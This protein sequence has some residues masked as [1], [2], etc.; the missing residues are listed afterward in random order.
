MQ[1]DI[2]PVKNKQPKLIT[3]LKNY[4]HYLYKEY[5][6]TLAYQ[7]LKAAHDLAWAR[8]AKT[9]TEWDYDLFW[10][11]CKGGNEFGFRIGYTSGGSTGKSFKL[12]KLGILVWLSNPTKNRSL[13]TSTT[14]LAS[15]GRI[16]GKV[17]NNL[18]R[19][20]ARHPYIEWEFGEAKNSI[21]IKPYINSKGEQVGGKEDYLHGLVLVA[22][23]K[24]K[25]E[26]TINALVGNHP[27]DI[28]FFALD[29]ANSLSSGW[30][31]VFENAIKG[32]KYI[33]VV[34]MGNAYSKL[35]L[36]WQ[37]CEPL[38]S[39]H[40]FLKN[41]VAKT[42]FGIALYCNPYKSPADVH[43]DPEVRA[44]YKEKKFVTRELL[45]FKKTQLGENS[46]AF[47]S[48][49]LGLPVNEGKD[50][51]I[52]TQDFI[53][54]HHGFE[55]PVLESMPTTKIGACDPAFSS[56]GDGCPLIIGEV[57]YL[58][59]GKQI[60]HILE[61]IDLSK[62]VSSLTDPVY[63]VA[64]L[65]K[66][67]CDSKGILPQNFGI[68][69]SGN[70]LGLVSILKKEWSQ[71][72]IS[73]IG[74]ESPSDLINPIR[75]RPA[76]QIFTNH[77]TELWFFI[78]DLI[79]NDQ[80]YNIPTLAALQLCMRPFEEKDNGKLIMLQK[81]KFR[82]MLKKN[83]SVSFDSPDDADALA[84]LCHVASKRLNL[85]IDSE[86]TAY[87]RTMYWKSMPYR[88]LGGGLI[89]NTIPTHTKRSYQVSNF[90]NNKSYFKG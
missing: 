49:W 2:T 64:R 23:P 44:F 69:S 77:I 46:N 83:P 39:T 80:L 11:H 35:D 32:S 53:S 30:N 21:H 55:S 62:K 42:K 12:S 60:L 79:S 8:D 20:C 47:R 54:L 5:N 82:E 25:D 3:L 18:R 26:N 16:W 67:T 45:E 17:I 89:N 72:I 38:D 48:Q 50:K 6:P 70:A 65:I 90:A 14:Y 73:V 19:L 84:I 7:N 40:D 13:F 87:N 57:G 28:Y 56:D 61:V 75:M 15:K 31:V 1:E 58:P 33:Q 41:H 63:E 86:E 34:A 43:P 51:T 66:Q 68:D 4:K 76:N 36:H 85:S 22:S 59:N 78:R 24:G 88:M 71:D 52:L 74:K 29:E 27:E 37:M 9:W 10:N 81:S